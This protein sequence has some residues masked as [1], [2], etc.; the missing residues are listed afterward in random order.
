MTSIKV[1]PSTN[2]IACVSAK[3]IFPELKKTPSQKRRLE[4][5]E[6]CCS[7]SVGLDSHADL[8]HANVQ[9][10]GVGEDHRCRRKTGSGRTNSQ[11]TLGN[12]SARRV[13][14]QAQG[15]RMGDA[16]RTCCE[17]IPCNLGRGYPWP[18]VELL[19]DG[20]RGRCKS[21][22]S[23]AMIFT[24]CLRGTTRLMC[25]RTK[26]YDSRDAIMKIKICPLKREG[27]IVSV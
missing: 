8:P 1:P 3:S 25:P 16:L 9:R 22:G 12:F 20:E 15:L 18:R 21:I 5:S 11:K 27:G 13:R 19:Y 23:I 7:S 6:G 10:A 17:P 14:E 24:K 2:P 26:D 4:R